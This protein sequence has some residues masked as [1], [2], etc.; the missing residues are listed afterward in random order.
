MLELTGFSASH[1]S[2]IALISCACWLVAAVL[3]LPSALARPVEATGSMQL[4]CVPPI[5]LD[6]HLEGLPSRSTAVLH[7]WATPTGDLRAKKPLEV[8]ASWCEVD[9]NCQNGKGT[10]LFKRFSLERNASGTY[11]I[12]LDDGRLEEG[13]FS[14]A[15]RPQKK[16]FL[17]E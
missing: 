12:K 14:V 15:K 13:S 4:V 16:P 1:Y 7:L 10:V 5:G 9:S 2:R 6:I 17:C 3:F 11:N 8:M